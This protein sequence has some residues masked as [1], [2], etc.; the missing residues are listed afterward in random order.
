MA[1]GGID[2]G[3]KP[4]P[5]ET[6]GNLGIYGKMERVFDTVINEFPDLSPTPFGGIPYAS[7]PHYTEDRR[8]SIYGNRRTKSI[9]IAEKNSPNFY[10]F[11]RSNAY[12]ISREKDPQTGKPYYAVTVLDRRKDHYSSDRIILENHPVSYK[13]GKDPS[14]EYTECQLNLTKEDIPVIRDVANDI[15]NAGLSVVSVLLDRNG[16]LHVEGSGDGKNKEEA[17]DAANSIVRARV[18]KG[19]LEIKLKSGT[20]VIPTQPDI[21]AM[22]NTVQKVINPPKPKRGFGP[23]KI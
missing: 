20:I 6:V 19:N 15:A 9:S 3:Q 16:K 7:L 23:F 5:V 17:H 18:K 8:N 10:T 11:P 22:N 4:T 2:T 21:K 13:I 1:E 14:G 12:S